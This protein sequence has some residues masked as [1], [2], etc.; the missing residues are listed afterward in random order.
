MGRKYAWS[1]KVRSHRTGKTGHAHGVVTSD[2]PGYSKEQAR[3]D[4]REF[5]REKARKQGHVATAFDIE[6]EG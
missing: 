4:V 1:A 5:V 3:E 2:D 6:L